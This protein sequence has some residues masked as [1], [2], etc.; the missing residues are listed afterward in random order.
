[1]LHVCC[2]ACHWQQSPA[3]VTIAEGGSPFAPNPSSNHTGG[4]VQA[5]DSVQAVCSYLRGIL[6]SKAMFEGV[7][8]GDQNATALAATVTWVLRDGASMVRGT[9]L[10]CAVCGSVAV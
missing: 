9:R 6:A 10:G 8:V 5:W 1:M 7:G 3:V 4:W 2:S